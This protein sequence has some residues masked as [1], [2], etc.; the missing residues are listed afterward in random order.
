MNCPSCGVEVHD[1][2]Q[3]CPLCGAGLPGGGSATAA[4]PR[5]PHC[6]QCAWEG[7]PGDAY[8]GRCGQPLSVPD[9]AHPPASPTAAYPSAY[10]AERW[11]TSPGYSAWAPDNSPPVDGR[12]RGTIVAI[13]A[14]AVLAVFGLAVATLF[15]LFRPDPP[16][17]ATSP[18]PAA[19]ASPAASPSASPDPS[20][21]PTPTATSQSPTQTPSPVTTSRPGDVVGPD[22]APPA[23]V[24]RQISDMTGHFPNAGTLTDTTSEPFLIAVAQQYAAS[25]ANG[26]STFIT[27]YS[28]V[29]EQVYDMTCTDQGDNT[30]ICSGGN[31]AQILLWGAPAR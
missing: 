18:P 28:S 21:S 15:G 2:H 5:A 9:P 27:A 13:I 4:P 31:N 29:T 8:C 16:A 30:V 10:S 3:E 19:A 24:Y 7:S 1:G 26:A 14:V 22:A 12:R 25:E 11:D 6:S 20:G 23:R 17:A